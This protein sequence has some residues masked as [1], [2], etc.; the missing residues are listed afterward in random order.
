MRE[1]L[2]SKQFMGG[3]SCACLRNPHW[4][5]LTCGSTGFQWARRDRKRS[6]A[7]IGR[8][9]GEK[10]GTVK[11]NRISRRRLVN[12][13]ELFVPPGKEIFKFE[14]EDVII[15]VAQDNPFVSPSQTTVNKISISQQRLHCTTHQDNRKIHTPVHTKVS[16]LEHIE[17]AKSGNIKDRAQD[18]GFQTP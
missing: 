6:Q 8:T 7:R 4:L 15:M 5:S 14:T 11:E 13:A 10:L 17:E 2:G 9:L 16:D 18:P 12:S 3:V 1:S